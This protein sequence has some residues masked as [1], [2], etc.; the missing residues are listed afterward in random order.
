MKEYTI[1]YLP[2]IISILSIYTVWITGNKNK[3]GWLLNGF[4]Q[5][6]WLIWIW[7]TSAWGLIPLNIAMLCMS[8][9]NFI[10]WNKGEIK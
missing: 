7:S 4:S 5:V 8:I 3:I 10:L 2:W 6:L 9:R 1:L